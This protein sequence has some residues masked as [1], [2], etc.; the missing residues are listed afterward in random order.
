MRSTLFLALACATTLLIQ[1]SDNSFNPKADGLKERIAAF[2]ILDPSIAVQT[3]RLSRSYDS[4]TTNPNDYTGSKD[5]TN[6]TVTVTSKIDNAVFVDTLLDDGTGKKT[7]AWIARQFTPR[8]GYDYSLSINVPGFDQLSSAVRVPSKPFLYVKPVDLP[9]RSRMIEIGTSATSTSAPA[10]GFLFQAWIEGSRDEGGKKI[11]VRREVPLTIE[12]KNGVDEWTYPTATRETKIQIPIYCVRRVAELIDL[13][14]RAGEMQFVIK[15]YSLEK[16]LYSYYYIVRGFG[17]PLTVR[18]DIPDYSN[19]KNGY[20]ILGAINA[21]STR[22]E[23]R[24]LVI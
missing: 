5:V 16:N 19:M 7:R 9:N 18:Q 20:G 12:T 6:A 11:F 22:A 4:P 24:A 23:Y 21:D 8:E 17:D 1:C 15:G 10:L 14:D 13:S 3:V 2:L